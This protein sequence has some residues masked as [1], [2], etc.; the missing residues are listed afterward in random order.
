MHAQ[1]QHLQMQAPA[2]RELPNVF[3][4]VV[5]HIRLSFET[6]WLSVRN[7]KRN[8]YSHFLCFR[9]VLKLLLV[10]ILFYLNFAHKGLN[11]VC[12]RVG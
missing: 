2:H 1:L 6:I 7:G 5:S 9:K 11:F 8:A 10:A 4:L 12:F 3:A